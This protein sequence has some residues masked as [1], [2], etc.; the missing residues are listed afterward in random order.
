MITAIAMGLGLTQAPAA[1]VI[2]STTSVWPDTSTTAELYPG[3]LWRNPSSLPATSVAQLTAAG[4]TSEAAIIQQIA[5]QPIVT[6]LG[7]WWSTP[8]LV[9]KLGGML[10]S[11]Q[12][13]GRTPVFTTYAIPQRDCGGYSAGGYDA[14]QYVQWNR[15]IADTLRGH[16][17]VVLIE[18][19]SIAMLSDTRCASIAGARLALI[20]QVVRYYFDA[21]VAVYLDGGNS[22]WVKPDVMATRL[23]SAGVQYA[24]GFFTNVSNFYPVDTELAYAG[25]LAALLGGKHFVIDVSRN[26]ACWKGTWCNPTGAALGQNPHVTPSSP[27]LDALL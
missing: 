1:A 15:T 8:L 5:S 27:G 17:A 21:G 23:R 18:P 9:S 6:W 16:P 10:T 19:D 11:A 3:G 26:G 12:A 22:H 25:S 7:D 20:A 4:N 24:R 2:A 14:T 13:A